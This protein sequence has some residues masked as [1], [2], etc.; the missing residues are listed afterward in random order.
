MWL[1][2]VL[3]YQWSFRCK[4]NPLIS[5]LNYK[6]DF[7]FLLLKILHEDQKTVLAEV[8]NGSAVGELYLLQSYPINATLR[9]GS[10][11]DVLVLRKDDFK[12][13]L[14]MYPEY[15]ATLQKR[16]DVCIYKKSFV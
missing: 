13:V 2:H 1:G 5:Y 6:S 3:R 15:M 7:Y 10:E 9:C 12:K 14:Q 4:E 16:V 11:C 8:R